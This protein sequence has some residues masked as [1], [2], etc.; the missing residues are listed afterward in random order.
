[1]ISKGV[2]SD[3]ENQ[4]HCCTQKQE[5]KNK[6]CRWKDHQ[7]TQEKAQKNRRLHRR[8]LC[9]INRKCFLVSTA[10]YLNSSQIKHT[11]RHEK[12]NAGYLSSSTV[13]FANSI[14]SII[15]KTLDFV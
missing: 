1:M 6:L 9:E 10:E 7:T 13:T 2:V 3:M 11:E 12:R 4:N 14:K 15:K 8:F 5:T